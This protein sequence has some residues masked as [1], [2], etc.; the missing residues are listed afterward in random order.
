MSK[1]AAPNQNNNIRFFRESLGL[2]RE[3]FAEKA[4]IGRS[5]LFSYESSKYLGKVSADVR[6]RIAQALGRSLDE[7]FP[8]NTG[9]VTRRQFV[10]GVGI[11]GA[12]IAAGTFE[13]HLPLS[14]FGARNR[15]QLSNDEIQTLADDNYA[16]WELLNTLQRGGSIDYVAAVAQ[17]KLVTLKHL[18]QCP[19]LPN[20]RQTILIL[21]ADTYLLLGRICRETQNYGAGDYYCNEAEEIAQEVDAPNLKAAHRLRYGH[22]LTDQGRYSA[23]VKQGEAVLV[24]AKGA[25]FPIWAESQLIAAHAFAHA[26]RFQEARRI[27]ECS[28]KA[29]L[30]GDPKIWI[31]PSNRL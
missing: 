2:T 6:Q 31:G 29:T 20:Q 18:S 15:Q 24:E 22:R 19:L 21:L 11:L 9:S 30:G 10:T 13:Q 16:H 26:G 17:G 28:R 1:R 23:A 3:Q 4:Q 7:V 27:A 8:T 12:G 25:S 14:T 5:T